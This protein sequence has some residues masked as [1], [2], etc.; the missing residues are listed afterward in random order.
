MLK[1]VKLG[2]ALIVAT[3]TSFCLAAP[4][5]SRAL[6]L[7]CVESIDARTKSVD[8]DAS[9]LKVALINRAL[10]ILRDADAEMKMDDEAFQK[11]AVAVVSSEQI[12]D[13]FFS[14]RSSD[15]EDSF[16]SRLKLP[17]M[18]TG[19]EYSPIDTGATIQ[20]NPFLK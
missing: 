10:T 13:A 8:D 19:S 11:G 1:F 15:T 7:R 16:F 12:Q 18:Q 5:R 20:A 9:G 14:D 2:V 3:I 4:E 6:A 17:F